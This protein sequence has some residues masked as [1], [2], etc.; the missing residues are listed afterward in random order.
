MRGVPRLPAD[1]AARLRATLELHQAG[2]DLMR[3]NL[4]RRHPEESEA[5]IAARLEAWLRA[6]DH[7]Y[8]VTR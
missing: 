1:A 4:R 3:Q 8:G 5:Q 6:I 2:V 7:K